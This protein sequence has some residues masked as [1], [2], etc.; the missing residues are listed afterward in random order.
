MSV[1]WVLPMLKENAERAMQVRP[2]LDIRGQAT[3]EY[4]WDGNVANRALE[5]IGKHLGMFVEKRELS[6]Q[7]SPIEIIHR[8]MAG[9]TDQELQALIALKTE[10]EA[11]R[12]D[13]HGQ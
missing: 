12:E 11:E 4:S 8:S 13:N 1:D 9:V 10:Y 5:L 2:V 7:S 6:V 3:G